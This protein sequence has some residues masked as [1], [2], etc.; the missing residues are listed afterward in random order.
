[1]K[2]NLKKFKLPEGVTVDDPNSP[3]PE[4]KMWALMAEFLDSFDLNG[5]LFE[6]YI[7]TDIQREYIKKFLE[8]KP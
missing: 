1:M 8:F 3:K 7:P 2:T 4:D 6:S 5:W